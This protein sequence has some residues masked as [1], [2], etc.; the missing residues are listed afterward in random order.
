MTLL[1]VVGLIDAWRL[2][3]GALRKSSIKAIF[4]DIQDQSNAVAAYVAAYL[5]PFIRLQ[6]DTIRDVIA[7]A[8]FFLVLLLVFVKSDLAAINPTLYATGW[9]VVRARFKSPD[10][11]DPVVVVL[12]PNGSHL[13]PHQHVSVVRF[14]AFLV[15]KQVEH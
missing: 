10:G 8:V 6:L 7:V 15:Q 11:T 2:P 1:T 14:G 12:I 13:G 4:Y 3:R 9:R 5:L